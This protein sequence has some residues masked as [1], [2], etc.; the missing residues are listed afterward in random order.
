MDQTNINQVKQLSF[1]V[2]YPTRSPNIAD[3]KSI[4]DFYNNLKISDSRFQNLGEYERFKKNVTWTDLLKPVDPNKWTYTMSTADGGYDLV[5]NQLT[6][7]AGDMQLPGFALGLPE[8]INYAGFGSMSGTD[9]FHAVDRNGSTYDELGHLTPGW[10]SATSAAFDKKSQC[11]VE[12]YGKYSVPGATPNQMLNINGTLTAAENIADAAGLLSAFA[13]WQKRNTAAPNPGLPGL[14][15]FTNDQMFFLSFATSSCAK[16]K[17]ADVVKGLATEK[18]APT[19]FRVNGPL[20]NSAE[21][22]KA[23]NCTV[24]K[25]TC[26]VW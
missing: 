10:D 6:Y 26:E 11:F 12:Q 8:Y 16:R 23:F 24:K 22:R 13:A 2:G 14:E 1:K 9:I 25:P 18:A 7:P 15:K 3:P 17:P 4:S 20:A 19:K 5:R 21:F